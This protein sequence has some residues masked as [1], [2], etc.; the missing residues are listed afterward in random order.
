LPGNGNDG[1]REACS[2][3]GHTLSASLAIGNQSFGVLELDGDPERPWTEQEAGLVAEVAQEVALHLENLRL[4]DQAERYR[5]EAEQAV[6]RMTR[7][8][9]E[10]FLE[11]TE[12]AQNGSPWPRGYVYDRIRVHP[13]EAEYSSEP[14]TGKGSGTALGAVTVCPITVR[15]ETIGELIVEASHG[16]AVSEL[17]GSVA[18]RLSVHIES[19]RLLEETERSRQQ[20]DRRAAELETVAR[21]STAAATILDPPTLLQSVVNLTKESFRLYG[22]HIYLMEEQPGRLILA[23]SAGKVGEAAHYEKHT[24]RLENG[25][26]TIARVAHARSGAI[27]PDIQAQPGYKR[28]PYYPEAVSELAVPMIVGEQVVGVFGVLSETAGRFYEDDM[29]TFSTLASQV[30]IALRNAE[31]YAEQMETVARLRELDQLKSAFLANMSHELRTPLNSIIGFTQV[32]REGLDG[33]LTG[34]MGNDLGLI[35]KNGKHLLQLI[36]DVLDMAKI[37]SGRLS[38]TCEPFDLRDLIEEVLE[39]TSPLARDK[40][41]YLKLV[42][43]PLESMAIIADQFRIR[44]ILLNLVGNALKF[45][46]SGGITLFAESWADTILV[47]VQDTGIGIPPEKLETIF[48]AFSQVDNSTTRKAGGTGLGLPISRRLVE[49]HGGRLWAVSNGVAG[50]GSTLCLELPVEARSG[51]R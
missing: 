35:E 11:E 49:M 40:S 24:V 12:N 27:I 1:R 47:R 32:I 37:E 7:Q 48:E 18:E 44:Q 51:D 19:L 46:D 14:G 5:N 23:A 3:P 36:N 28:Y 25:E 16:Q 33:P 43:N 15:Q 10:S 42:V 39:T 13:L 29:R 30:A 8:G 22:V 4:L 2:R 41:L 17:V 50:E 26:Y 34:E 6:R 31:L 38:L 21:V 9:W 45:T 20:L